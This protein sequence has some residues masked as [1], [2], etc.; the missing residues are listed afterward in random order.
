MAG[1]NAP[2]GTEKWSGSRTM[3]II[4]D[5]NSIVR[6]M[7]VLSLVES[8]LSVYFCIFRHTTPEGLLKDKKSIPKGSVLWSDD[9]YMKLYLSWMWQCG[10]LSSH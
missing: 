4:M 6:K 10:S 8:S 3:L 7:F 2:F 1:I 9:Y 5:I